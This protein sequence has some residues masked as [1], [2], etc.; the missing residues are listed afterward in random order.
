M[1]FRTNDYTHIAHTLE[2]TILLKN[3]RSK[4][5]F[6]SKYAVELFYKEICN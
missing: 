1:L 4:A 2:I 3:C 5:K 6:F